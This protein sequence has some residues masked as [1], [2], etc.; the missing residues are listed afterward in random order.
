LSALGKLQV[1]VVGYGK[2][3]NENE[4]TAVCDP[5]TSQE[6]SSGLLWFCSFQENVLEAQELEM[7]GW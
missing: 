5:V 3:I 1:C 7:D 2:L 6:E 4:S